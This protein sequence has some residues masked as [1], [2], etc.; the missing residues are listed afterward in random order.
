VLAVDFG[1]LGPLLIR[2]GGSTLPTLPPRQRALLAALLLDAGRVIAVGELAETVW[3]GQP[4][5]SARGALH[6]AMQRLRVALGPDSRC[7]IRTQSPGYLLQLGDETLDVRQFAALAARGQASARVGRWAQAA[8]DFAAALALWRGEPLADVPSQALRARVVPYLAEQRL[9]VLESRIEADLHSGDPGPLVGELRQ[10]VTA[11]MLRERFHSQLMLALYRAGRQADALAAYQDLH[12]ALADELGVDPGPEARR[13]HQRILRGDASLLDASCGAA[14]GGTSGP[15]DRH[16]GRR[17]A[18]GPAVPRQLPAS[19]RHF[20]G[21]EA[22]LRALTGLLAETADGGGAVVI[23][24]IDGTAGVGKTALAIH[25]AHQVAGRFPDGQLHVNLRGFDPSGQPVTPAEAIRG[26]LEALGVAPAGIPALLEE[27]A[28]MYRSL[29][30]GKRVLVVLDNARDA[31]QVRS[32]LPGSPACL[33]VVTSRS[34]LASLVAAEG[35]QPLPLDLPS[36]SEARHMLARRLGTE[37]I[38]ADPEAAG[39]L[40]ELCARLP[41]ALSIAAARAASHPGFPLTALVDELRDAHGRL[42]ALD[43]GDPASN[44]A[45]V[46]SWS[47]TRLNDPAARMFRLLS[48]HPGPDVSAAACASLAGVPEDVAC[49]ALGELTRAHLVTEHAPGRFTFHDLL[50]SY[51]AGQTRTADSD[52]ERRAAIHRLLDHYLHTARAAALLINP[53]R[54]TMAVADP[55]PGTAPEQLTDSGHALAWFEIEHQ[56]LIGAVN[57]AQDTGFDAHA[58]RIPW[59]LTD[60]LQRRGHWRECAAIQQTALAAALRLGDKIGQAH[61]H[62]YLGRAHDALGAHRDA[63]GHYMEALALWR[64]LGDRI[65]QA[66]GHF[67][68]GANYERQGRYRDALPH[69]EQALGLYRAAGHRPGQAMALNGIG[70]ILPHLGNCQQAV[71]YCEQAIEL[72]RELGDTDGEAA[73]WDSLGSARHLLGDHS[74]AVT[75]Y[76]HALDAYRRAGGRQNEAKVLVHLGGTWESTGDVGAARDAWRRALSIFEDLGNAGEADRIRS[77][78][79]GAVSRS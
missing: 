22:E 26:F 55:Q 33:V 43:A 69:L 30:A 68:I 35:A 14:E 79:A 52:A 8:A 49:R 3:D 29:L 41:L 16:A 11:H 32:L 7:L 18:A 51:A 73:C 25:F 75:C 66:R 58:W 6:T 74:Q 48:L 59:A 63:H 42:K 20:A 44:L 27:R 13:L 76:H 23:S 71:T 53:V 36:A 21:R 77:K 70:W 62:R 78:L 40:I 50:R 37:R 47:Y 65:G 56:V 28:A 4:P 38:S 9:E 67:G 46:F 12:R 45:A 64:E 31:E 1:L 34:Q 5:P 24:A 72:C 60:F 2:D 54:D 15:A 10:L 19:V 61:A 17:P 39:E 57:Q